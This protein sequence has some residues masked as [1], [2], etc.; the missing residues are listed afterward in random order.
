MKLM[1]SYCSPKS[2]LFLN[3]YL[4]LPPLLVRVVE[5]G[6]VQAR[7]QVI[8]D[9]RQKIFVELKGIWELLHN[10]EN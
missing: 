2:K 1:V 9:G 8:Q 10:L 3:L 4:M 5:E 6:T 7:V